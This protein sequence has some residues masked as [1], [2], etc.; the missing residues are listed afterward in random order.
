MALLLSFAACEQT[1]NPASNEAIDPLIAEVNSYIVRINE[2]RILAHSTDEERLLV[3]DYLDGLQLDL[4]IVKKDVLS[5]NGL[6]LLVDDFKWIK[7]FPLGKHDRG[8]F[9]T[10]GD[11]LLEAIDFCQNEQDRNVFL[12]V[13][14]SFGSVEER[15]WTSVSLKGDQVWRT[16]AYGSPAPCGVMSGYDGG[17]FENEDWLVSPPMSFRGLSEVS[18]I[19]EEAINYDNGAA[20]ENEKVLISENYSGNGDPASA[21]WTLLQVE[22]RSAGSTWTFTKTGACDLTGWKHSENVYI[23][24]VYNSTTDNAS[25]WEID[26]IRI[27]GE[28][29]K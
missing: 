12:F 10:L 2:G 22:D 15:G 29:T 14:N 20:G 13:Q 7:D 27:E 24:F 3:L 9:E 25:T 23:A 1:E 18:L 19:F 28:D 17:D 4:E 16:G 6:R 5:E 21:Q 8:H 11:L 26:N